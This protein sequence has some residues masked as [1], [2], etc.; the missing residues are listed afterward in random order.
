MD[1][2]LLIARVVFGALFAAHG[3]Q[4]LFGWFG[5]HGLDGTAQCFDGLGF[6]PGRPYAAA[7]GVA[8]CLGGVFLAV[9]LVTPVAAALV[10]GVMIVAIVTVHRGNGLLATGN[11]VELPLLYL[12][13]ALT[14][15]LQGP[16]GHSLDAAFGLTHLWTPEQTVIVLVLGAIAAFGILNR[17]HDMAD[18]H[19]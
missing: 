15:A 18:V 2:G 5:G 3:S 11:G 7:T 1:A 16:G 17:R 8:E 13:V 19:E 14:V 10:I 9:G 6:R 4:K 12:T